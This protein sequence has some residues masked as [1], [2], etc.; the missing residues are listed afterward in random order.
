MSTLDGMGARL[1]ELIRV[2]GLSQ[3]EFAE[4][5]ESSPGFISDIARGLKRPGAEVLHRIREVFGVSVDWLLDGN[6][7]MYGGRPI[8]MDAFKLISA[9]VELVRRARIDGDPK[10]EAVLKQ[11]LGVEGAKPI[12]PERMAE[13]LKPYVKLAEDLLLPAVIYNSHLWTTSAEER[14][15]GGLSS[16]VA[17]FESKRPLDVLKALIGDSGGRSV[18]ADVPIR[19]ARQINIGN[20]V[21]S[22]EGNYYE[23]PKPKPKKND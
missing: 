12:S 8:E 23:N 19:G 1:A 6:G 13:L 11:L 14:V 22:A 18:H 10:A 15:R 21:R 2:T 7:A 20:T 16:V 3:Q 5:L 9:Q 4:R 17:Y